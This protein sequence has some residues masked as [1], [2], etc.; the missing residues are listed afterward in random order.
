MND[1]LHV[2][3]SPKQRLPQALLIGE[4]IK[5]QW[6]WLLLPLLPVVYAWA[7]TAF[8]LPMGL[9]VALGLPLVMVL[10]SDIRL[11]IG[12][13]FALS[14]LGN[15]FA[16]DLPGF[17]PMRATHVVLLL[18]L[19][20]WFIKS[21]REFPAAVARFLSTGKNVVL[22]MLLGWIALS[23]VMG[24]LTGVTQQ[25]WKYQFNA[26]FSVALA[27]SLALLVSTHINEYLLKVILW[28]VVTLG[29]ALTATIL[30]TGALQGV[31]LEGWKDHYYGFVRSTELILVHPLYM[32]AMFFREQKRWGKAFFALSILLSSALH[33]LMALGGSR[34]SLFPLVTLGLL[35]LLTR[36]RFTLA[37]GLV[38]ALLV[39]VLGYTVIES[40]VNGQSEYSMS[41]EGVAI[42]KGTR[43]VLWHDA[44]QIIKRHPV[45]GTGSD[46]YRL[47]ARVQV[48][49]ARPNG[50]IVPVWATSAHNTWLQV[51]VD[52]GAPAAVLLALFCI[53]VLRDI[54][55]LYYRRTPRSSAYACY[56]LLFLAEFGTTLLGSPFGNGVLPV[57][58]ATDGGEEVQ[59]A[60]Y[61]VR[62][63]L[64]YG[65]VL[66]I[67][68]D[69]ARH[70]SES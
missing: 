45:W 29:T 57:F 48:L 11:G 1:E 37:V 23:M 52:H 17:V 15:M 33:L 10:W 56:I 58:T 50:K 3:A 20:I 53:F 63:W 4:W 19:A 44:V 28:V 67:E 8:A 41:D 39:G 26:W 7:I 2:G 31:T 47:H 13:W 62:F 22:L 16:I 68:R 40:W 35:V 46:L 36:P 38:A 6:F 30:V 18:L 49:G 59:L 70:L 60:S 66:G 55:A 25:T 42:G 51:A 64:S 65:V 61:L 54:G 12:I 43:L 9:A 69:Q 21:Y 5:R 14:T 32:A 24:R 27:F 34:S